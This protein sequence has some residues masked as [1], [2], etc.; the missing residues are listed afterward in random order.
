MR[1]RKA[2]KTRRFGPR[3]SWAGHTALGTFISYKEGDI[4]SRSWQGN[5]GVSISEVIKQVF[6]TKEGRRIPMNYGRNK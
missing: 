5:R 1:M 3:R 6:Q 4:C 2:A